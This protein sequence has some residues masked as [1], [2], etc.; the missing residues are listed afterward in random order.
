V[1]AIATDVAN[2]SEPTAT[3]AVIKFVWN[4]PSA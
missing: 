2:S 3:W 4:Q 1:S